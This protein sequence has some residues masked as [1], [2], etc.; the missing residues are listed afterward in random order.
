MTLESS[1]LLSIQGPDA[2]KFLQG[3]LTCDVLQLA[4][5]QS[6]LGAYCNIKG[7][8]Q[9]VFKLHNIASIFMLQM[10]PELLQPTMLELQKYA[11]FSQVSLSIVEHARPPIN[12]LQ[13]INSKIPE[14]YPQTVELFFPHDINLPA[15]GA[16]SFT[17]GCYRGQEI[18]A[19]MQ[20]RGNLKRSMYIFKTD[21]AATAGDILYTTEGTVAGTVV[22]VAQ[23]ANAGL[24]GLAVITDQ[25]A[26]QPLFVNS[27]LLV[28]NP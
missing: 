21:S 10:H 13:E 9:S 12:A 7:K 15:L 28:I 18:V 5:G 27:A 1:L 8:V 17:K 2:A 26:Q 20:H 11:V 24:L 23:H 14:I 16:V 22:R 25:M 19:R 3:Q 6:I 4:D